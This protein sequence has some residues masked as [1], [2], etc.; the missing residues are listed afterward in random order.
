MA[1]I[2]HVSHA[3]SERKLAKSLEFCRHRVLL[4]TIASIVFS[5][6]GASALQTFGLINFKKDGVVPDVIDAVPPKLLRVRYGTID[7]Q[8]GIILSTALVR[9]P[10]CVTFNTEPGAYYTLIMHD[11]DAPSRENSVF[12]EFQHWLVTNIPWGDVTKGIEATRYMSSEPPQNTGLHRYIFLLYKQPYGKMIFRGL[13]KVTDGEGR[14]NHSVRRFTKLYGLDRHLVAGTFF[15]AKYDDKMATSE[16]VVGWMNP[17]KT[18]WISP[19]KT[20]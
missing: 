10:P 16:Q 9:N 4:I 12:G 8:P 13:P 3:V 7:V 2:A 17:S 15:R 1:H 11:P 20:W 18:N 6:P 19:R 5:L 14:M